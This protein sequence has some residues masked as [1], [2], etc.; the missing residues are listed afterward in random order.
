MIFLQLPQFPVGKKDQY[1]ALPGVASQRC[2]ADLLWDMP[3]LLHHIRR[4]TGR[5]LLAVLAAVALYAL[6][7]LLLGLVSVNP[8][9]P[10]QAE[11]EIILHKQWRSP[12]ISISPL[13]KSSLRVISQAV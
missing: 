2:K 5:A 13:G 1:S 11:Y 8:P 12:S 10:V 3:P 9:P 6:A 4:W 7:G